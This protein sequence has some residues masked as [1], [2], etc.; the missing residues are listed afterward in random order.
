MFAQANNVPK[1][2]VEAVPS[3]LLILP[4][5]FTLV[6]GNTSWYQVYPNIVSGSGRLRIKQLNQMACFLATLQSALFHLIVRYRS[7]DNSFHV[8]CSF[9]PQ[10]EVL[11]TGEGDL[12]VEWLMGMARKPFHAQI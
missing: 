1:R 2:H 10:H 9:E 8:P 3:V 6:L 11:G 12:D 5:M 4:S 7:R